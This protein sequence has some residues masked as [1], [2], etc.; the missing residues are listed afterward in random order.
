M[1]DSGETHGLNLGRSSASE[2]KRTVQEI[3]GEIP[4]E[5]FG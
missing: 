1:R 4:G 2:P 3:L 5:F